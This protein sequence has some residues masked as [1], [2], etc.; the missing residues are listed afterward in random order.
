ML[1]IGQIVIY[2][3]YGVCEVSE[4][5]QKE[6]GG[7][8]KDFF[9]LHPVYD[10]KVSV[11]LPLD[12]SEILSRA[13]PILTTNEIDKVITAFPFQPTNWI[14]N[15]NE[16]KKTYSQLIK[17]GNRYD[18]ISII[19]SIYNHKNSLKEKKKKLHA[20][21]EQ[22][23]KEAETLLFDEISYVLNIERNS[24]FNLILDQYK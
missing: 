11:F 6:L 12:N 24:V 19:K 22:F 1:N 23:Y 5:I 13:R 8:K 18:L 15:D 7:I 4:I 3:T 21:D 14:E 10:K 16:R 9:V 20:S 2:N 17:N